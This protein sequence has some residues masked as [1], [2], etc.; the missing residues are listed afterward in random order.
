MGIELGVGGACENKIG[1]LNLHVVPSRTYQILLP[2]Q[3]TENKFELSDNFAEKDVLCSSCEGVGGNVCD[4]AV[5]YSEM[6]IP[7]C[8]NMTIHQLFCLVTCGRESS[9]YTRTFSLLCIPLTVIFFLCALLIDFIA[10]AP[11]FVMMVVLLPLIGGT[12]C[13]FYP[14]WRMCCKAYRA[15]S[16][17]CDRDLE[18]ELLDV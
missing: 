7:R 14:L 12:L 1:G 11:L 17:C 5:S 6:C 10:Y 3:L 15:T 8:E 18:P 13:F 16:K 4:W 9:T 2:Y